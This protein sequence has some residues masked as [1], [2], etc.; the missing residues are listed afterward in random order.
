MANDLRSPDSFDDGG[1]QR[2]GMKGA[3]PILD[4]L[5]KM[6]GKSDPTIFFQMVGLFHDD[7][8]W[9][10]IEFPKNRQKN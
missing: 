7:L 2:R 6:L 8:P 9:D 4:L 1:R 3:T 5:E 10:R